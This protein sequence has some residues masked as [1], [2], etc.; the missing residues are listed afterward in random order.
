MFTQASSSEDA[1]L[2]KLGLG[3]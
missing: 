1:Y 3:T 2:V